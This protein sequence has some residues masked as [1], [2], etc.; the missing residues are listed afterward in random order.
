MYKTSELSDL[1]LKLQNGKELKV[2]KFVLY[3]CHFFK[4]A[5]ESGFKVGINAHS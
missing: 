4:A 1:V 2:H 5:C 3:S